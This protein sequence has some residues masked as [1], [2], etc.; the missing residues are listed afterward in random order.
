MPTEMEYSLQDLA[1]LTGVTPRTIRYYVASGLLPSPGR[2]GPGTTYGESHLAR[3]RLIRQLA[4]E[5]LPLAEIR[6]R[7]VSLDDATVRSIAG[8]PATEPAP[9]SAADYIRTV[10]AGS[11]HPLRA[12]SPGAP[13]VAAPKGSAPTEP[14][15]PGRSQWDRIVLVP[16]IELHIRRPLTRQLNKRVE[17]LIVIARQLLEEDP[18]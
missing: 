1:D 6:A 9:S 3:L 14:F 2:V 18:S 10:L 15:E 7:L 8:A 13:A 17:R 5:H 12:G 11:G 4:S 16:D